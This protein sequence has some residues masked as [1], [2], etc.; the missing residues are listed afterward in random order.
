MNENCPLRPNNA[1]AASKAAVDLLG[2]QYYL[3][4]GTNVVMVR[5]F[6]HAGPRQSPR[7]VL[8]SLALHV[9]E[10]ERG[11]REYL[12]VG[13]LDVIR[14]FIDVRDVVYA[15][16]RLAFNGQAGEIYNLGSGQGT[17]IADALSSF[18][19]GQEQLSRFASILPASVSSTSP[20]LL[21]ML[22]SCAAV[23]WEPRYGIRPR[24]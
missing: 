3:A 11:F 22:A 2:I 17:K 20:Y 19:L 10:V 21:P 7:Y 13:N 24:H 12:E 9:A 18:D 6:N 1:Y 16:R 23:G 8:A 5:P 4:H 14:D 15:Y